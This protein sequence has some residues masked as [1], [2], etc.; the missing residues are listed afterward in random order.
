[1]S[2]QRENYFTEIREGE[3]P[4]IVVGDYL[5]WK[6]T[7]LAEIYD[8]SLYTLEY[9]ARIAGGSNEISL[10]ATDGGGYFLIQADSTVTASYN[11]GFYHWQA[12]IIR[13]S[14]S[15]RITV[16]RGTTDVI[17]DLDINSSDP[18][19][20]SEIMLS[21]IQGLL[22]GKAD[23][24]VSSYSIA[25]RSLTKMAFNELIEAEKYFSEKVR[26]ETARL[27]AKN[28]RDT[29]ATVQVRF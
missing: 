23:Q 17:A 4:E 24:D 6:K 26:Q 14:D 1:M 28:H 21:K 5:Q 3:P 10:T 12:D 29:G 20:H 15:N 2:L 11:P 19:T 22:E 9:H 27:E 16:D 7:D 13:I 8:P 25:G 18:R